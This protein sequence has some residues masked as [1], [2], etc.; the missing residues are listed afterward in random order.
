MNAVAEKPAQQFYTISQMIADLKAG[1]FQRPVPVPEIPV[2]TRVRLTALAIDAEV[3]E[4]K[5]AQVAG[6]LTRWRCEWFEPALQAK[7]AANFFRQD[8]EVLAAKS[9]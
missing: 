3:I 2:G 7:R 9:R 1:K 6:G 8:F 5:P 4:V